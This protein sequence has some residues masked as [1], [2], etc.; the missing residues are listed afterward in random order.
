MVKG[1]PNLNFLLIEM[2]IL[3][4]GKPATLIFSKIN[5]CGF[6]V[7]N[8]TSPLKISN[9][10]ASFSCPNRKNLFLTIPSGS[11]K[12]L[13]SNNPFF[14]SFLTKKSNLI[15]SSALIVPLSN[16]FNRL[17]V[18]FDNLSSPGIGFL[19]IFLVLMNPTSLLA[20]AE[21]AVTRLPANS[22]CFVI[23]PFPNLSLILI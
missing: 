11:A 14:A 18:N 22:N 7:L 2:N 6:E 9:K 1:I 19:I 5:I 3:V 21:V 10:L 8:V 15:N 17:L 23:V 16:F 13:L 4:F 12:K 20:W